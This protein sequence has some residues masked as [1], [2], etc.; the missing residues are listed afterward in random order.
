MS[1]SG[2]LRGDLAA[3]DA[4]LERCVERLSRRRR[5]GGDAAPFVVGDDEAAALL[6]EVR[7]QP[8]RSGV[9]PSP[10]RLASRSLRRLKQTFDASD[11]ELVI[12]LL[13]IAPELDSRYGRLFA[14]LNDRGGEP[15]PTVGLIDAVLVEQGFSTEQAANALAHSVAAQFGVISVDG[16]QPWSWRTVSLS[17]DVAA[18]L[19]DDQDPK[20]P[21]VHVAL[22]DLVLAPNTLDEGASAAERLRSDPRTIVVV[23]GPRGAGRSALARAIA[24]VAGHRADDLDPALSASAQLR[25]A[26]WLQ[27]AS[28]VDAEPPERLRALVVG[29]CT[30]LLVVSDPDREPS[31]GGDRPIVE[32]TIDRPDA[33]QRRRAWERALP[34]ELRAAAF[35]TKR[36]ATRF[37]F[38][39]GD[40][41][42][43]A[44]TARARRNGHPVEETE[45]A[46]LCRRRI[47]FDL[48]RYATR[49]PCP[50]TTRDIVLSPSARRELEL[51]IQW[52]RNREA[53][54]SLH[55][56]PSRF[57]PGV[58]CLFYGP[59]GT[60]KTMSAQILAREVDLDLIRVDLS[61]VVDK[62]I[63]ETE[64]HLDRVFDAAA[65][66]NAVLFFDEADALFG[67]RTEVKDAHDRYANLETAYLLQ[68]IEAHRGVTVLATNLRGN[69]DSAFVRRFHI[70]AELT[71]PGV[72]ERRA[73]W[74]QYL[75]TS[76]A[77]AELDVDFLAERFALSGADVRNAVQSAS[78]LALAGNARLSMG[79]LAEAI[80]RELR[81]SGR[82]VNS[83]DFGP[84]AGVIIP[85]AQTSTTHAGGRSARN[86]AAPL[87]ST[88]V[89]RRET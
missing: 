61:Q 49:L 18:W 7:S 33:V 46:D 70:I 24:G 84:W 26:R 17:P 81:K 31:L 29:G 4:A 45:L 54:A 67:K 42:E 41:A 74:H 40:L 50:F 35:D 37:A 32:V 62:Y 28:I 55:R 86:D 53:A 77:T 88:P 89:S 57:S 14:F 39:Y 16:D 30:P 15:R 34:I 3:L 73:L 9:L 69:L 79:H 2:S 8:R 12:V 51:A 5:I 85:L 58:A 75:P 47:S 63:G 59:P 19:R 66:S 76:D 72:E 68:R 27:V 23:R 83:S 43:V 22:G 82:L 80:W 38:G 21:P 20:P 10:L 64:K 78:V 71:M 36:I 25:R 1:T 65:S 44:A 87:A 13:A 11:A 48:G 56:D 60:G 6:A 52:V